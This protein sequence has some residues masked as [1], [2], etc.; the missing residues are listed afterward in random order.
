MKPDPLWVQVWQAL[1]SIIYSIFVAAMVGA[2]V[3]LQ[4]IR[5][6][7]SKFRWSMLILSFLTGGMNGYF[8]FLICDTAQLSWQATAILTG[9]AGGGGW[10]TLKYIIGRGNDQLKGHK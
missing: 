10:E 5:R 6:D 9:A 3:Y 4:R 8:A 1:E 2:V 7:W